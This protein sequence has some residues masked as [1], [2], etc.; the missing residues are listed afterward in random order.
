MTSSNTVK[1]TIPVGKGGTPEELE[2]NPGNGN[3]YVAITDRGNISVIDSSSNTVKA[4]IPVGF[5][6]S[7]L[8]YVPS[9]G[10][11]YVVNTRSNSVSVIDRLL[12]L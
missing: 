3:M 5:E 10:N 4:T 8:E 2:Y 11:I 12:I 9:N 1:A 6:P 7:S